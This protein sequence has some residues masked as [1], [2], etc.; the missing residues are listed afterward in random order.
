[1]KVDIVA[2]TNGKGHW[3]DETRAVRIIKIEFGYQSTTMYP[4][5]PWFGEVRAYFEPHGFTPDSWNVQ[6]HGLIYTD[7]QWLKEF[8]AGL[9]K[10]GL[11]RRALQCLSYS[12]QGMQGEDYV[13][14]DATAPFYTS[15]TRVM[16]KMAKT[17][18]EE[19]SI[20]DWAE[21]VTNEILGNAG[22]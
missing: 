12:E 3:T 22:C 20:D 8:K 10:L 5:D 16:K 9:A 11:S 6:G 4:E 21:K 14:M 17:N 13:S 7:K 18:A 1:M 19:L 15:W 2:K